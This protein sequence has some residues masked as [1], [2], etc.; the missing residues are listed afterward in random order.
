MEQFSDDFRAGLHGL[1]KWR[2][3]ARHFKTEP[4]PPHILQI[5][6]ASLALAPFFGL[7]E[8]WCVLRISSPSARQRAPGNFRAANARAL[9]GYSG[10]QAQLCASL[11]LSGMIG[12][13][14][15]LT[16]F[17]DD[18]TIEGLGLGASSMPEMRRYSV[19]GAITLMWLTARAHG[20]VLGWVSV[21][22]PAQLPRDLDAP[23]DWTFVAY[24]C[25]GSPNEIS[26]TPKLETKGR[27]TRAIQLQIE[28]R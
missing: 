12:A 18:A 7:S 25:L 26:L 22:N 20:S 17:C 4:F 15:Q 3:D 5:Y 21:L 23:P 24:L 14:E 27:E 28:T 10:E 9:T 8:P 11:K 19:A 16:I 2:R 6:L 13:P 1:M